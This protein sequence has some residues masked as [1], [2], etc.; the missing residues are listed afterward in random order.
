M[1]M[2][3]LDDRNLPEKGGYVLLLR[4]EKG[5]D[6][7]IGRLGTIR[8]ITGYYAYVGSAMRGLKQRI[9]RH[10]RKEKKLH[11]H[12]DFFIEKAA[13]ENVIV[14]QSEV[15]MEC[16]IA[17]EIGR[18]YTVINKFGSSDCKCPGH[19]YFSPSSMSDRI[20]NKLESAGL[21]PQLVL[22]KHEIG[23]Q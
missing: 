10:L 12:I 21:Q 22:S 18:V 19:L 4:L 2:I 23:N 6:I 11:W 17:G 9:S 5:Q 14:C 3:I 8:F 1:G 7:R 15:I 13:I 16:D 20:I